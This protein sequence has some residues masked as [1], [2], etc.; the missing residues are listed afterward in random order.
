MDFEIVRANIIDVAV[1][2]VVVPANEKLK[3][4]VLP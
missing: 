1:D 4:V 2:A 3:E